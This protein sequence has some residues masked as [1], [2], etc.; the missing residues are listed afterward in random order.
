MSCAALNAAIEQYLPL[1]DE[2]G[3]TRT[4][5][6]HTVNPTEI[7]G[8]LS[9]VG[10]GRDTTDCVQDWIPCEI[11]TICPV[12]G[13]T[14]SGQFGIFHHFEYVAQAIIAEYP[15]PYE[16][17]SGYTQFNA[18]KICWAE[19]PDETLSPLVNFCENPGYPGYSATCDCLPDEGGC[20]CCCLGCC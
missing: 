9:I 11:E 20:H 5:F 19:L 4:F 6:L 7:A 18:W 2:S 13:M 8:I 15:P 1:V 17:F 10:V 14:E 16:P 3:N 12:D